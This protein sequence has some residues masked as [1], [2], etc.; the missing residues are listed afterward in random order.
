MKLPRR[1]T[2]ADGRSCTFRSRITIAVGMSRAF[3]SFCRAARRS[4]VGLQRGRHG[5]IEACS[6]PCVCCSVRS[7]GATART[8][9]SFAVIST[10]R[11]GVVLDVT[12]K[13]ETAE[14]LADR[15]ALMLEPNRASVFRRCCS[16]G[17]SRREHDLPRQPRVL[18]AG[19]DAP[20]SRC[21]GIA[22]QS[23][24]EE[25]VEARSAIIGLDRP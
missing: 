11:C 18:A 5:P 8:G 21:V 20:A 23:L 24:R 2:Y 10:T 16:R 19:V 3:S 17:R 22:R 13:P 9:R 12:D 1:R 7:A 15:R 4:R 25:R 14:R 6:D